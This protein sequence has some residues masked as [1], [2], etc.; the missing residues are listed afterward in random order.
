MRIVFAKIAKH[1]LEDA[2]SFYETEFDGL[3]QRFKSEVKAAAIRIGKYP[4]MWSI[5]R[6][7]IRKMLVA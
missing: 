6:G 3:G 2:A 5:E 1:E 4:K 7:E